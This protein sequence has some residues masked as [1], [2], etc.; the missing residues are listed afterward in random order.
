MKKP[1]IHLIKN[2]KSIKHYLK[3]FTKKQMEILNNRER[4]TGIAAKKA[5]M[6]CGHWKKELRL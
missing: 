6:I 5:E 1:L 3:K 2:D 4:Y